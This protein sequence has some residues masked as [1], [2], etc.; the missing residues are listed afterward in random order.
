MILFF[1]HFSLFLCILWATY[2]ILF[3]PAFVSW[4]DVAHV[5]KSNQ[6]KMIRGEFVR[7]Y[8]LI[9]R[10]INP[11]STDDALPGFY[12]DQSIFVRYHFLPFNFSNTN[13][14]GLVESSKLLDLIMEE[15]NEEH[16]V[17]NEEK[18]QQRSRGNTVTSNHEECDDKEDENPA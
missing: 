4:Y 2:E 6:M 5:V 18:R 15:G 16:E 10:C 7:A 13:Y 17:R 14:V 9:S 3:V 11:V 8:T 12:C 1:A